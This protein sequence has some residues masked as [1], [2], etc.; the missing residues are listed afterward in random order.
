MAQKLNLTVSGLFTHPNV[1]SQVPPGALAIADNGVIDRPGIFDSRRGYSKYADLTDCVKLLKYR[2][3]LIAHDGASLY[4]D[5]AGTFTPFAGSV[6]APCPPI[7]VQS[8]EQNKNLYIT[9]A[10]GILKLDSP[11]GSLELAG[12]PAG[13]DTETT[14]AAGTVIEDDSAVAYRVVWAK[15]DANDVLVQGAPSARVIVRN[16]AGSVQDATLTFTI[17]EGLT[18]T[19][20]YQIYRSEQTATSAGTPSDELQLVIERSLT[21]A[22]I[23]AGVVVVLDNILDSLKGAFIYTS[24]TQAGILQANL[25]PPLSCD[26]TEF[27]QH[28]FYA[29]VRTLQRVILNLTD[30]PILNDTVTLAGVTYTAKAAEAIGSDEF[31]IGADTTETMRSLIRVVNRSTSNTLIYAQEISNRAFFLETRS[32]PDVAFSVSGVDIFEESLPIT[33]EAEIKENEVWVSRN[34]R[35]GSVPILN[36]LPVGSADKKIL[37][38]LSVRD[39]VF[40]LKLDG[41]YRITGTSTDNFIVEQ[42]DSTIE[43]RGANTASA[44]SN[45]VFTM[46]TQGVAAIG[47]SGI[48]FVSDSIKNTL[49]RLSELPNFEATAWGV[50]YEKDQKYILA[51]PD[52]DIDT[53]AQKMYV[54]NASTNTWTR[55]IIPSSAGIANDNNLLYLA[56]NGSEIIEERKSFSL[57]DYADDDYDVTITGSSGF[58]VSVASVPSEVSI[59][60]TLRQGNFKALITEINGLD[61]TISLDNQTWTAGAA[62]VF[63]PIHVTLV[64]TEDPAGNPGILKHFPELDF[65][66]DDARFSSIVARYSTNFF[67]GVLRDTLTAKRAGPWGG[68]PWGTIPW[69]GTFGGRRPIRTY[70]PREVCRANWINIGLELEEAFNALSCSG[71]SI[72]FNPMS[73]RFK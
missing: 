33:S 66:F 70:F 6:V 42:H 49:L 46:T 24:S 45:H 25:R 71:V 1:F 29:N 31:K 58:V 17:P 14:I 2:G 28:M 32:Y 3:V 57:D 11:T 65:F 54:F 8:E 41:V 40:V 15:E 38:I 22:E 26:L 55:W 69:G 63:T 16:S 34:G 20:K 12:A 43:V 56:R 7:H 39:A 27:R 50:D 72:L 60:M 10:R 47:V 18:T 59:G 53:I 30:Q 52:T 67:P 36:R 9:S 61:F 51:V 73:S 44:T 5:V 64:W 35:P 23:T 37:R 21:G 48:T 62:S 19:W 4:H 68:F 13:L